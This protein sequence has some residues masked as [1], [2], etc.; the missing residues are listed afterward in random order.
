MRFLLARAVNPAISLLEG[1]RTWNDIARS[2]RERKR[3]RQYQHDK[4]SQF[5]S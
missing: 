3:R 2:L 5:L 1:L 4:I